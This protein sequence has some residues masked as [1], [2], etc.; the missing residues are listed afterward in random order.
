MYLY[1]RRYG[2]R[3]PRAWERRRGHFTPQ[4]TLQRGRTFR[5]CKTVPWPPPSF[6]LTERTSGAR[7]RWFSLR[8][9][10]KLRSTE[11]EAIR[12]R[13]NPT[14][15]VVINKCYGGYALS[16]RAYERLIELGI[17]VRKY[18]ARAKSGSSSEGVQGP[19]E[20]VILDTA[21]ADRPRTEDEVI[22]L[23]VL[24]DFGTNRYLDLWT[25]THRSDPL[26]IR[27]VEELG[28]DAS[29]PR[30]HLVVIE[31][32]DDVQYEIGDFAGREWVAEK[33]RTWE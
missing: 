22:E 3:G 5:G 19:A 9:L 2:C 31:I 30:A 16:R 11:V 32:P 14:M 27:V 15:K 26:L 17:P 13:F 7:K 6:S 21:L 10:H 23:D 28:Q 24:R 12:E 18:V 29:G 25:Y 20:K 33:H 4:P 8:S 1:V